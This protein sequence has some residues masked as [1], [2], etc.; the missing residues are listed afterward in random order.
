MK[1]N[2]T[3][4]TALVVRIYVLQKKVDRKRW[5]AFLEIKFF[6]ASSYIVFFRLE[7]FFKI[8]NFVWNKFTNIFSSQ[9]IKVKKKSRVNYVN[10]HI[11]AVW[12]LYHS[13]NARFKFH[14][15]NW[16]NL[17]TS[18]LLNYSKKLVD[19]SIAMT[20]LESMFFSLSLSVLLFFLLVVVEK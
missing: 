1:S 16:K 4:K 20:V 18:I 6:N 12:K 10:F 8:P 3:T 9:D 15:Q 14:F 7:N 13:F 19:K 2:L 5:S 17:V 11:W